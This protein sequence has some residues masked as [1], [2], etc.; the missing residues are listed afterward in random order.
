MFSLT[1]VGGLMLILSG[2][3]ILQQELT[4]WAT[5]WGQFKFQLNKI[6]T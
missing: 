4:K 6:Q 5:N 1:Y 2:W 3:K